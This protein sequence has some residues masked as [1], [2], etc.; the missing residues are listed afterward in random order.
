VFSR[1]IKIANTIARNPDTFGILT[2]FPERENTVC[3][4]IVSLV[5]HFRCAAKAPEGWRT[6]RPGGFINDHGIR[7]ASW[8][9][10][11]LYRFL[12]TFWDR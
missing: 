6:P 1:E 9:A 11:V 3:V 4:R 10:V 5:I 7:E 8:T 2:F 12:L